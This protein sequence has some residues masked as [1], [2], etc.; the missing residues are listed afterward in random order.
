MKNL[1]KLSLLSSLIAGNCIASESATE[2]T[3]QTPKEKSAAETW[4]YIP[5]ED[6]LDH[7]PAD[8]LIL[9]KCKSMKRAWMLKS[10]AEKGCDHIRGLLEKADQEGGLKPKSARGFLGNLLLLVNPNVEALKRAIRPILNEETDAVKYGEYDKV[11]ATYEALQEQHKKRLEL[12]KEAEAARKK[13]LAKN[14]K[15]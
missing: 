14:P 9:Q 3:Q 4:Q 15:F 12:A 8:S 6:H 13:E 11:V 1:L 10:T 5:R 2:A 7:L